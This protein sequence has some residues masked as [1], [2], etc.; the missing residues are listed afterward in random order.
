MHLVFNFPPNDQK[1]RALGVPEHVKFG[2]GVHV[3]AVGPNKAGVVKGNN[4]KTKEPANQ[5]LS[6]CVWRAMCGVSSARKGHLIIE[7]GSPTATHFF[8]PWD[9]IRADSLTLCLSGKSPANNICHV[10]TASF[11]WS[12][13]KG[14]YLKEIS[15][16]RF[17]IIYWDHESGLYCSGLVLTRL[18][19]PWSLK[20]ARRSLVVVVVVVNPYCTKHLS[21]TALKTSDLPVESR[22]SDLLLTPTAFGSHP[23]IFQ[24]LT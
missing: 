9:S 13:R 5:Q 23:E 17:P 1:H 19:D 14:E 10:F 7:Q 6:V 4:G 11:V 12:L 18:N 20:V 24:L 8:R 21:V 2:S 22:S 15:F 16:S 3:D